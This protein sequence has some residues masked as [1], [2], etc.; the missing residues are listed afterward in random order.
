[1]K[2]ATLLAVLSFSIA[3][4]ADEGAELVWRS[5]APFMGASFMLTEL[6]LDGQR[7][8]NALPLCPAGTSMWTPGIMT[9]RHFAK[10][11][12]EWLPYVAAPV[13]LVTVGTL[14]Q[15]S[16]TTGPFEKQ[17]VVAYAVGA[18]TGSLIA[19]GL[20]ALKWDRW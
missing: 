17:D 3:A 16:K 18:A 13:F 20:H 8:I 15:L 5:G 12:P 10:P 1:M 19:Y 6:A 14:Y 9:C 7:Q 4:H 11:D 2:A